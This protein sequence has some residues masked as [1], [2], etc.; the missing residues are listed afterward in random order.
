MLPNTQTHTKN[1]QPN[2]YHPTQHPNP[3]QW[4]NNTSFQPN[5][6][7]QHNQSSWSQSSIAH[8]SSR[9]STF[10]NSFQ[11]STNPQ[12]ADPKPIF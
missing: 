3:N 1:N 6:S 9:K 7:F 8:L 4:V 5:S 12:K 10:P 2:P 11:N